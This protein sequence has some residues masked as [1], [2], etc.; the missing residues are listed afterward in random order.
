MRRPDSCPV[1]SPPEP[2]SPT[3][4]DSGVSSQSPSSLAVML[5]ASFQ[6]SQTSSTACALM[7]PTSRRISATA[8]SPWRSL[9]PYPD[10]RPP[11]RIRP[12][13]RSL[14]PSPNVQPCGCRWI[15]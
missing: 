12:V 1:D 7:A 5:T 9:L 6:S 11:T 2:L 14:P 15:Q 13:L 4:R 10:D 8:V 3:P